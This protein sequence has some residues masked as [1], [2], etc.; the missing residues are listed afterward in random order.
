MSTAVNFGNCRY[1]VADLSAAKEFYSGCFGV[2][3]NFDEPTWVVFEIQDYQLWLEPDSTTEE[4]VYETTDPFYK[5]ANQIRLNFWLVKDVQEICKRFKQLG[6]TILKAP[7]KDGP[8]TK[9][10]V[11]DPWSN[12]LGL[13]SYLF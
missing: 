7:G 3:P 12:T 4:S 6:G 8:F 5:N 2:E 10:I 11:K 1:K 9:A 13:H